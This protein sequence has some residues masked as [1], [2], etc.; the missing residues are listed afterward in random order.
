MGRRCRPAT[1]PGAAAGSVALAS[2]SSDQSVRLWKRA[3]DRYESLLTV[4]DLPGAV[5]ELQFSPTDGRLL[6]LLAQEHAV[7]V[8]DVDRLKTQLAELK[9]GW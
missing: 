4:S 2:G 5:R 8:W 1:Q 6:V 7:R 3:G 9:L